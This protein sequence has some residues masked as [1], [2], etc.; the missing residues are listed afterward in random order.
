MIITMIIT[1]WLPVRKYLLNIFFFFLKCIILAQH[2]FLEDLLPCWSRGSAARAWA[3]IFV[4]N[5]DVSA[6]AFWSLKMISILL[7]FYALQFPSGEPSNERTCIRSS[8]YSFPF[9]WKMEEKCWN[10]WKTGCL[11]WMELLPCTYLPGMQKTRCG[12]IW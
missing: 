5:P 12:F 1:I 2:A 10:Y 9:F 8:E 4:A 11:N 6:A 7:A 3:R